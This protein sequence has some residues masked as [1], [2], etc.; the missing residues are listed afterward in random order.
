MGLSAILGTDFLPWCQMRKWTRGFRNLSSLVV[1]FS[2][3][4]MKYL[5]GLIFT[6]SDPNEFTLLSHSVGLSLVDTVHKQNIYFP[7]I[8]KDIKSIEI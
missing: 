2:K 1:I 7:S 8:G 6:S 4:N 5:L 3:L